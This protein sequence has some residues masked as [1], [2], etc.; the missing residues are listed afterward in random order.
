MTIDKFIY[1]FR[2]V[3]IFI[4]FLAVLISCKTS[5]K[6]NKHNPSNIETTQD[7]ESESDVTET[8]KVQEGPGDF[9]FLIGEWEITSKQLKERLEG[10]D[11]WIESKARS[12]CWKILGGYGNMDEFT[13]VPKSGKIYIG[14]TV[15][16]YNPETK[17]WLLY[18][19]DNYNLGLGVTYQTKGTFENGV[20][21]FY[22]EE[23]FKGKETR[24]KFTWKKIDDNTAY[25]DQ[26]YYDDANGT[27]E[28]NWVMEFK[29]VP[30]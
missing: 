6:E 17:E 29:K 21:I 14:N 9:D 18:W 19:V 13:M 15:R 23:I 20:G 2:S 10:S 22:G 4:F 11:E 3:P 25:W 27:W 8:N 24:Q 16:V 1:F 7:K 28:I 30:K 12:K 26:A 5:N